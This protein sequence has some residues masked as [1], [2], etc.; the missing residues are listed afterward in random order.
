MSGP[1]VQAIGYL[2]SLLVILSLAMRSV[3]RLRVASLAGG[4]VYTAYGLLI[5][6]WPIVATNVVVVGL[7][8]WNLR[9]EFAPQRDLAAVPIEPDAPFLADFLRT[10]L[11]DIRH[12]QPDFESSAAATAFVLMRDGMPAGAVI[13]NVVGRTFDVLLDYVLPEYRDSRL[14][15]WFYG[16]PP[17]SVR[18]LGID[19]FRARPRTPAHHDYLTSVGFIED[20]DGLYRK[21]G[22]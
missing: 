1:L 12:S 22:S 8:V 20:A 2:A 7:N 14:G 9:R 13:G 5:G 19:G 6:S 18:A 10:H 3:V 4:V 21:A 16:T 17:A 11:A 15:G